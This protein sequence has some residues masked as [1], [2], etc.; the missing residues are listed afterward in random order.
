M[1]AEA[2]E[3]GL[4]QIACRLVGLS[5]VG[6]RPLG[7]HA[8]AVHLLPVPGIV[9]RISPRD[10]DVEAVRRALAMTT[11]LTS[12]GFPTVVPAPGLDQPVQVDRHTVS[13]WRYRVPARDGAVPGAAEL[14]RLLHTLHE[15]PAAPVSLPTVRPL[16][17]L[18]DTLG[19]TGSV[20]PADRAWLL[21]EVAMLLE[22][23][24]DLDSPL[25]HGHL[26]G[27]AYPGN[28]IGPVDD[29][30]LGDWE[31]AA[32]GPREVDLANTFQGVRFGRTAA[33]LDAF[34]DSY[35]YD[36]RRWS[37]MPTLVGIRDLHTLGA[38]MRRADAGDHEARGELHH[39]LSTLRLRDHRARWQPA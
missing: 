29:P 28:L 16:A 2:V 4:L 37:G 1:I 19:S 10:V 14:G 25:G 13:F 15:L 18:R 6:A 35:G 33:E 38:Y 30:V 26:H 23:Y 9:V 8:T 7:S 3:G 12:V 39:R 20:T 36:L 32:T 21:D 34:A 11:W 17:A 22:A 31:E 5:S 27:D 24:S